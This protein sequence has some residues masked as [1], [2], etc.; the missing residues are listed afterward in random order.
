M[1][2]RYLILILLLL[3]VSVSATYAFIIRET[4]SESIITFGSIKMDLMETTLVGDEEVEVPDGDT[5]DISDSTNVSR[6]VR[7]K[8]VGRHPMY[9]RAKLDVY[10]EKDG[11]FFDVSDAYKI[12]TSENWIYQDGYYYY[13]DSLSDNEITDELMKE[14]EFDNEIVNTKY[15][16]YKFN[17]KIEGQALQSENNK[18]NVLEAEGWP[19]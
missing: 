15:Q 17:L 3:I 14:I 11:E 5:L 9:V 4:D 16:G 12:D 10:G 8:N 1:K 7:V 19:E 6:I 13:K 18:D 2:K